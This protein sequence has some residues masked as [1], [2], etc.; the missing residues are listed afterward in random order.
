MLVPESPGRLAEVDVVFGL[1]AIA[2]LPVV[3]KQTI[4]LVLCMIR[5]YAFESLY[6]ILPEGF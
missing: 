1:R 6:L 5:N 4:E 3:L 2:I